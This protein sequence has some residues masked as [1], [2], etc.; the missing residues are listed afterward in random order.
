VKLSMPDAARVHDEVG[1]DLVEIAR[2][3]PPLEAS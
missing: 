3:V 1:R 2:A